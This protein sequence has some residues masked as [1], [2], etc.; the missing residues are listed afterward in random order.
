MSAAGKAHRKAVGKAVGIHS[1]ALSC[2]LGEN[3][4]TIWKQARQGSVEGMQVDQDM[5]FSGQTH[6][7]KVTV[8]QH[9]IPPF[10][11]TR[12]NHLVLDLLTQLDPATYQHTLQANPEKVGVILGTSTSAVEELERALPVHDDTGEWPD[13]YMYHQQRMAHPAEFLAQH[14]GIEGPV[15]AVSTACSSSGKALL[16]ARR[17]LDQGLCDVVIAGGVD[18]LCQMTVNGF[19]ALG[20]LSA[21][22]C[23]PFS[24]NRTGINIG[25]GGGLFVL[26]RESADINL[27]GGGESS[28]AHHISAPDPTGAGAMAAINRALRDAGIEP[29]LMDYVNLHG[30]GTQQ[31]DAMEAQAVHQVFGEQVACGSTKAMTGHALGAAGAIEIG[32]CA[33]TLSKLNVQNQLIPHVYDGHYDPALAPL[34]L[35][36]NKAREHRL[37]RVLSNSFAFGGSNV[38]VILG[39]GD[40]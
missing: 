36:D 8:N 7:G 9:E 38:A 5:L 21:D 33:L 11:D 24:T 39:A 2:A 1:L 4:E 28:D 22:L 27:L 19:N 13:D 17:W 32:L 25:E 31:N 34:I 3:L 6:L 35:A 20:A 12:I 30:T 29:D 16:S 26:R 10:F 15:M 23:L 14:L 40:D 37:K 18:V